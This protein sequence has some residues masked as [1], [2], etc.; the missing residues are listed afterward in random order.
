MGCCGDYLY[1]VVVAESRAYSQESK[2]DTQAKS[3]G[4]H[5]G[6]FSKHLGV[7]SKSGLFSSS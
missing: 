7:F 1:N 4:E 6:P 5:S 2:E 3:R